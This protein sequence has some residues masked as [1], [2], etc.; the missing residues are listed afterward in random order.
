MNKNLTREKIINAA[1]DLFYQQGFEH[2]SFS[3]ISVQVKVSRGNFY[4][5]FKTKNDILTA[6]IERRLKNTSTMLAQ[7]QS[8][9]QSPTER[10]RSFINILILNREKIQK[11]GCPVGTL[12]SELVKLN[13]PS[14]ENAKEI[15]TQFHAW[16]SHQFS[17]LKHNHDADILAMH[18]LARSQGIATLA[19]VFNDKNYIK[20]EV[21]SLHAW[22]TPYT[23]SLY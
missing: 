5:H 9:G 3:Q 17:Q 23:N 18:L 16:L 2:T 11:F 7:W 19:S 15:F 10:I 1:D 21:D 22:L 14:K 12:N 8:Q 20:Q 6:V 13:H 4:Y